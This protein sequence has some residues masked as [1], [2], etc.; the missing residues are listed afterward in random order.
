[1]LCWAFKAN[2]TNCRRLTKRE[3]CFHDMSV[4]TAQNEMK[5]VTYVYAHSV[6][7]VCAPCREGEQGGRVDL[8]IQV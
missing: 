5:S 4:E 7:H 6:T 8:G 2:F 3:I 1:M